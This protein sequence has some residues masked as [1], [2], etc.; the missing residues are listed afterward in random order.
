MTLLYQVKGLIDYGK[1]FKAE[2]IDFQQAGCLDP[3]FVELCHDLFFITAAF[4]RTALEFLSVVLIGKFSRL[5]LD[6]VR[7]VQRHLLL[8]RPV[9]NHYGPGVHRNIPCPALEGKSILHQCTVL[10]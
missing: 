5:G 2:I 3:V 10:G 4:L 6:F 8:E 7:H 9:G 1:C